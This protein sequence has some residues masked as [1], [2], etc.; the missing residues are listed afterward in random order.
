MIQTVWLIGDAATREVSYIRHGREGDE[1]HWKW[2]GPFGFTSKE[3]AEAAARDP[4]FFPRGVTGTF[5]ALEVQP[6]SFIQAIY[7]GFPPTHTDVF[8]LD[9][10]FFPLT[11]GGACWIDD[12]L[13]TPIWAPLFDVDGVGS[14]LEWLDKVLTLVANRLQMNMETVQAIGNLNAAE[15]DAAMAE[16]EQTTLLIHQHVRVTVIPEPG[17]LKIGKAGPG[18]HVLTTS[19]QFR[20]HT[21]GMTRFGLPE[22]EVRR[23]PARWVTAAG[24]ELLR[25][26]AYSLDHGICE[27]DRLQV[28]GPVVLMLQVLAS[29]EECWA[30]HPTGCLTLEVIETTL[31]AD[32][33]EEEDEP[34]EEE[35]PRRHKAMVH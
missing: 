4:K 11:S 8:V 34:E 16:V 2:I 20:L 23:V 19:A 9:Q 27:G 29:S 35:T 10:V 7:N 18:E 12:A 30:G 21:N 1:A 24:E 13:D 26:A 32:A 28:D 31:V 14:G 3:A 17:T 15:E 6:T 5:T 22:L 25:W 33:P